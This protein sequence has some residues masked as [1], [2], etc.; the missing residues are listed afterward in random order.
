MDDQQRRQRPRQISPDS[1]F[2]SYENM[3]FSPDGTQPDRSLRR[4]GGSTSELWLMDGNFGAG[5]GG[6]GQQI[7]ASFSGSAFAPDWAP[8]R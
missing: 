8:A 5:P 2:V 7:T 4:Q 1:A 6:F 3:T